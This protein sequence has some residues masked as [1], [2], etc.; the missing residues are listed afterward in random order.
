MELKKAYLASAQKYVE[1]I[2]SVE[3]AKEDDIEEEAKK[4]RQAEVARL[5]KGRVARVDLCGDR[6]A[7]KSMRLR[8]KSNTTSTVRERS[9][10]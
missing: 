3:E 7:A 5:H 10:C 2:W 8:K 1:L 9:G 4:F 6:N